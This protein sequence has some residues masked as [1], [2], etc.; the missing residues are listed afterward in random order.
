MFSFLLAALVLGYGSIDHPKM[1][2]PCS[3]LGAWT[4]ESL[5][6]DGN[7]VPLGKWRQLKVI[8]PTHFAWVGQG[9][10]PEALRSTADTVAAYRTSGFG[11]GTWRV[12]DSSYWERLEYFSDPAFVGRELEFKC[13]IVGDRWTHDFEWPELENGRE[14]RRVRVEEVWRRVR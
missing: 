7:A 9:P 10:G 8:G 6:R 12:S 14:V 3:P 13:R 2:E 4:L 5:T 1:W 11:G